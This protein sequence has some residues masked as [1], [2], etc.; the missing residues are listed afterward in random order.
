MAGRDPLRIEVQELIRVREYW[1]ES[2]RL[3]D[4]WTGAGFSDTVDPYAAYLL[5]RVLVANLW[6]KHGEQFLE[7]A[8]RAE[9]TDAGEAA[10]SRCF[11]VGLSGCAATFLGPGEWFDDSAFR[12]AM[13]EWTS[14]DEQK[15]ENG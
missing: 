15:R 7:F 6:S 11:G 10:A 8:R 3:T 13:S 12:S 4:F 5:A 14:D 9:W 2:G 1:R